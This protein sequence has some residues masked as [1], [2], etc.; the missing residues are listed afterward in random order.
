MS[1]KVV[2]LKLGT[3]IEP[4]STVQAWGFVDQ[5]PKKMPSNALK[6]PISRLI[7]QLQQLPPNTT[8]E[9]IGEEAV[10]YGGQ[11]GELGTSYKLVFDVCEGLT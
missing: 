9:E 6:H 7:E 11:T 8:Y 4:S 10:F 5:S 3:P 2:P 1:V